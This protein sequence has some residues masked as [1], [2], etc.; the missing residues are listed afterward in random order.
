M[1]K[2]KLTVVGVICYLLL[3]VAPA[4]EAVIQCSDVVKYLRPCVSYLV[5]GTGK[6]PAGCCSGA[7]S[8]ASAATTT[9]DKRAACDCI[10]T[11]A[12]N[13]NLNAQAAQALPGNCG[14]ALPF[15]VSPTVDCSKSVIQLFHVL[16]LFIFYFLFIFLLGI[17]CSP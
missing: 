15:T 6:P 11:V 4:S 7:S 8:L 16:F 3:L 14:I 12:K 13:I 1:K 10:K 17:D 2:M 5:K 9:A